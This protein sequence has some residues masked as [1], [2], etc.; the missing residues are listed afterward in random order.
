MAE[1]ARVAAFDIDA[2]GLASLEA[3]ARAFPGSLRVYQANVARQSEVASATSRAFAD[4]GLINGLVNCAGIYRDGLLV[5][6]VEGSLVKMPLAQWQTV[7]DVDL[8]GPFL[9]AREVAGHMIQK[10]AGAGVIINISSVSRHGNAGQSNYSAAKSGV[11]SLGRVWARE[12]AQYGIRV[13][14]IAPGFIRTPILSAMAPEK[15]DSWIEQVPLKRLGEPAE[16]FAGVRFVIECEF[17]NGGCV[18]ID[19]GLII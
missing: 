6:E 4:F 16:I 14:T 1:G 2:E 17:F 18:E 7:I 3:E 13:A 19:G 9:M 15:L 5:R 8:T 11:V 10:R 12:L